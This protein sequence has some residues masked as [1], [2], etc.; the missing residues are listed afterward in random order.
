MAYKPKSKRT[1]SPVGPQGKKVLDGLTANKNID[2]IR[3]LA[4]I[5]NTQSTSISTLNTGLSAANKGISQLST[6]KQN[7]L[8]LTTNGTSGPATLNN[9]TLNVPDYSGELTSYVPYTGATRNVDLG[10]YELKAGQLSLDTT[11]TG[12]AAVGTTRWNDAIGSSETTL[13]G[14]SVILKNGIDLVAR[15]VNKVTPNTTLTKANYPAVRVSGAQGQ[16]LAVA[17][18]QANN[19]NNSADTIGLVIETIATNQEGFIMTVGQLE[20]VNTTGSLQGETWVDG[21]VLYL[22]P[23]TPGALTNIKPTGLTGH[24]VVMGYVEYAHAIHGKIYVK[25]MNGWELDELHNVYINSGT[26]ANNNLL[27]YDS[28]DQLWKNKSL[29]SAG[30]Q[31]TITLTTTGTS[32]PATLVGA[33]LN[34]PQY[35][36]GGSSAVTNLGIGTTGTIV[37]GTTANTITQSVLIPANTLAANNTLDILAR[38]SKTGSVGGGNYR[39]YINTSNTLTGATLIATLYQIAGGAVITNHQNIRSFFYNGTNLTGNLSAANISVT[40]IQQ[41][42][43][44]PV[45]VAYNSATAYHLI[46][47]IQLTSTADSSVMTAYRILKYA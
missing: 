20:G 7:K 25:I 30:I 16:R 12:T 15:V 11:P 21:D 35:S 37:T 18:A 31:P 3:A 5:S 10:E 28:A 32:G 38:F 46:F 19:D 14:G 6:S 8:T 42:T 39:V 36:G 1:N 29:S 33:T 9:D 41:T 44:I 45:S 22:S 24:I 23:T 40:D 47:A 13:K 34:V 17:Y 43:T 2:D 26:L 27:Q 4:K